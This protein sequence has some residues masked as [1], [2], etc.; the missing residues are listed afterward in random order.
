MLRFLVTTNGIS[1]PIHSTLKMEATSS[2][3]MSVLTRATRRNIPED[4]IL[5]SH[6]VPEMRLIAIYLDRIL[7]IFNKFYLTPKVAPRKCWNCM[8]KHWQAG[9]QL[10]Q[11]TPHFI[12]RH[13][14]ALYQAGHTCQT[15]GSRRTSPQPSTG[16]I[17]IEN[18]ALI[19]PQLEV[20]AHCRFSKIVCGAP[21][22]HLCFPW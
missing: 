10:G 13:E 22:H 19:G 5:H 20:Q 9:R 21:V 6:P 17:Q 14:V 1:S 4:G 11:C 15:R 18:I 16:A 12:Q 7:R 2:S 8:E 3:G